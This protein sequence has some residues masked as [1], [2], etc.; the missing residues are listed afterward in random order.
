[1][2]DKILEAPA[3]ADADDGMVILFLGD[4]RAAYMTPYAAEETSHRLLEAAFKA[5]GQRL[6]KK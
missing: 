5:K 4:G 1:M 2:N 6:R 3:E